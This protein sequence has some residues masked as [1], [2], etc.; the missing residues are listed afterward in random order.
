VS[1]VAGGHIGEFSG[2]Q[3]ML[4][5]GQVVCVWMM[6]LV[7]PLNNFSTRKYLLF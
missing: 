4:A 3:A 5:S 2:W 1:S 6:G 7:F